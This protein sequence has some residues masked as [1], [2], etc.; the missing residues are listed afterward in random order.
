MMC[1]TA[2]ALSA[3]FLFAYGEWE[4]LT[5]FASRLGPAEATAWGILG[6]IWD[7]LENITQSIADASEVR[8]ALLLGSS[9][10]AL[11]KKSAYKSVFIGFVY[12]LFAT[13]ILFIMGDALPKWFTT[14]ETIQSILAELIPLFGLGNITLTMGTMAWTLVGAQGRY[15][16]ATFVGSAGS[17]L[18]TIPMSAI[19][20]LIFRINLQGQTAAVVI[21]YMVSGTVLN[22]ILIR[23]NW[24]KLS[25][26]VVEYNREND[27][28][29]SDDEDDSSEAPSE[30]ALSSASSSSSNSSSDRQECSRSLEDREIPG[31]KAKSS[32]VI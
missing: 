30:P 13:S 6:T 8:V 22:A 28:S 9:K 11:A 32:M 17:W 16:L 15:R 14:S 31:L 1:K 10:P 25:H 5:I 29:L 19:L 21:G 20:T 2:T 24:T 27:I 18:I 7:L 12:S 3:G 26:Q 23:S 4:I